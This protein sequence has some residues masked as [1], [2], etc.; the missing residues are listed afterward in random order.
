[1]TTELERRKGETDDHSK[2]FNEELENIKKKQS[3]LMNIITEVKNTLVGNDSILHDL[4]IPN[5]SIF[6][7]FAYFW[8]NHW[9]KNVIKCGYAR[10][11]LLNLLYYILKISFNVGKEMSPIWFLKHTHTHTPDQQSWRQSSESQ[12]SWKGKKEDFKNEGHFKE[13]LWKHQEY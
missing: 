2:N 1:M 13:P 8:E 7:F 12:P 10:G 9:I 5:W 11:S 6:K 3:E 4:G